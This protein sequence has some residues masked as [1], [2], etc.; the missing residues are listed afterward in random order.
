MPTSATPI[1]GALGRVTQ[2][3]ET[4]HFNQLRVNGAAMNEATS[5]TGF[6]DGP[7]LPEMREGLLSVDDLSS[8]FADVSACTTVLAVQEKG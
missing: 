3:E 5:E 8:L 4:C 1:A 7:P 2:G 6:A